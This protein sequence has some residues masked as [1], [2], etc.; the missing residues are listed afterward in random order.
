MVSVGSLNAFDRSIQF[1]KFIRNVNNGFRIAPS[2][3]HDIASEVNSDFASMKETE[4]CK[5][6]KAEMR[7][8][9]LDYNKLTS[10]VANKVIF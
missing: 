5:K 7:K 2:E 4:F 3:C 1:D 8:H 9:D 6:Y 10:L